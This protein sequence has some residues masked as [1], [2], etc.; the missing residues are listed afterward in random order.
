MRKERGKEQKRE[1]GGGEDEEE[2]KEIKKKKKGGNYTN[3]QEILTFPRFQG[4]SLRSE[5]KRRLGF[6]VPGSA[7]PSFLVC[8]ANVE[9]FARTTRRIAGLLLGNVSRTLLQF[10]A[11]EI[12]RTFATKAWPFFHPD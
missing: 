11:N 2:A 3:F 12:P 8:L 9:N 4:C 7:A 1:G 5:R 6:A 10:D